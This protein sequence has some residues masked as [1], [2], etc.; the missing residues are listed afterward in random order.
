L[1]HSLRPII[2]S[3]WFDLSVDE[4]EQADFS[5]TNSDVF[6]RLSTEF[7]KWNKRMLPRLKRD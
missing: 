7:A 6:E 4:H 2:S 3:V 5:A 1:N